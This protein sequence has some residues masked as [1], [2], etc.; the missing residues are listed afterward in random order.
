VLLIVRNI[1]DR[2][3]TQNTLPIFNGSYISFFCD[4]SHLRM[5]NKMNA[6]V[7]SVSTNAQSEVEEER[8]R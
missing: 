3:T 8:L 2:S 1:S 4:L 7:T 5:K 6:E